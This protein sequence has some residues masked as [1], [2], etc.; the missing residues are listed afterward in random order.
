[1]EDF[2][3]PIMF[4]LVIG[5]V[6]G[7][8]IGHLFKRVSTMAL[9]IAVF[10]FIIVYLAYIGSVNLNLDSIVANISKFLDTLAPLGL[11]TLASSVPFVASFIAGIF[12]GYRR[13]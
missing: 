11:T 4:L 13:Y 1:M 10:A 6:S 5:G 12:L 9:T 2:I 8:V 3:V 7:Y